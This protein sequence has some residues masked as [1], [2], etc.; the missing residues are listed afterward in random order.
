MKQTYM[1]ITPLL[2]A[3]IALSSLLAGCGGGSSSSANSSALV[4]ATTTVTTTTTTLAS[5]DSLAGICTPAGEKSWVRSHLDDV[6]LWYKEIIGVPAANY[7]T[8]AEYF[9]ALLVKSKDRFSFTEDQS[10]ADGFFQTGEDVSYGATWIRDAN[11]KLRVSYSE[12]NS[13]ASDNGIG[14]GTQIVNINGAPEGSLGRDVFLA[15]LY[16]TAGGQTNQF[17]VL[18]VGAT[19]T[20]RVSLTA[21]AVTL[22]P[23]PQ[24]KVLIAAGKKIGYLVFHEHIATAGPQLS[25]AMSSFQSSGIDDLVL[26]VRYN[27]GGYL[28]I[29]EELASMIGGAPVQGKVAFKL[30]NNDKHANLDFTEYFSNLDIDNKPLPQLGMKRV[31]V[32]TSANTC[33]ASEAVINSLSPFMQVI[34]I[35]SASC[36]KPYGMRQTNNCNTAYFAIAFQDVNSTGQLVPTTGYTP[37]C[38]ASDNVDQQLGDANE[39]L[40]SAALKYQ[41]T[42]ACPTIAS[43]Q[44]ADARPNGK[45]GQDVYRAPLRS[46]LLVK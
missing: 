3:T 9:D 17:D 39:N 28:Y 7:S 14:R 12:P 41:A 42:G 30:Q 38:A 27:G 24:S 32:L 18:D 21:K 6:Y 20:R 2:A 44:S 43:T 5:A 11:H 16:P 34:T 22:T 29:A 4:Q 40:L 8:S 23:V 26:D 13:P 1:K 25:A 37:T 35:G 31:F 19:A 10:A 33:S 45:R 36:G 46:N 15:V